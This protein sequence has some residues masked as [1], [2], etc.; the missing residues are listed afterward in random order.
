M[1]GP[2]GASRVES[3]EVFSMRLPFRYAF[4]HHLAARRESRPQIARVTLANGTIG[5]GEAL[6]RPYLTGETEESVGRALTGE[7][8]SLFLGRALAGLGSAVRLLQSPEAHAAR[9]R[10]PAA[11]CGWDLALLDAAGRQEGRPVTDVLGPVRRTELPYQSAVVGHL[12]LSFL[13]LYLRQVRKLNKRV[14]KLKVGFPDDRER[15]AEV[16][17]ALG[18]HIELVLDANGAWSADE[19]IRTIRGLERFGLAA[20]EQPVGR[21]DVAGLAQVRRAVGT[22]IVADESICTPAEG[23]RLLDYR[24]CDLWNLRIGKC[25]GLLGT[26]ELVEMA[27]AGG[28][29]CQLGVLVGE[30]G[31]LGM[32]G[33]LLAACVPDFTVLEFDSTGMKPDDVL[34]EPLAPVVDNRAPVPLGR[35]GLGIEVDTE[36]LEALSESRSATRWNASVSVAVG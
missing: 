35:P 32:A 33:R 4:V 14:V 23:R 18:E 29:G 25:G 34:R 5:Y 19:A 2:P 10:V 26:L 36:R 31:I 21:E 8:A 12:P 27:A 24:A 30:T 20:V 1:N 16:R 6:P 22:P 28:V 17:R 13:R 15:V 9:E 7:L 3:L 11:F